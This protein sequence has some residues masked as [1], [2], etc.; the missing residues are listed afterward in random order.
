MG[1]LGL[2]D[3]D[4]LD[5]GCTTHAFDDLLR[6]LPS[7]VEVGTARLVRLWPFASGRTRG[8]A[9][10]SVELLTKNEAA[11]MEH[12]ED[13]WQTS[14][15]HLKGQ[16]SISHHS[17]RQ[18][19]STD[20][21]MV[22]FSHQPDES[23]YWMTVRGEV[24]QRDLPIP[25]KEWG[26]L[27][28][29]G[30]IAAA[31]WPKHH[32]T[33]EGIAWRE[34]SSPNTP[35]RVCEKTLKDIDEWPDTFLSR[36]PRRGVSLIAP[37]GPSPVLLGVRATSESTASAALSSLLESQDTEQASSFRIFQTNQASGDHL[38]GTRRVTIESVDVVRER[39]HATIQS[40]DGAMI[41]YAEGGPINRLARWLQP[42]DVVDVRGL[43][44]PQGSLHIEQMKLVSAKARQRVRPSCK[45]C[46]VRMKSM[47][48][49]QGIRCPKC[50]EQHAD[51]WI[52]LEPEPPYLDWI[53]PP[54]THRR[55]LARPLEWGVPETR[56]EP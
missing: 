16:H 53:E 17:S 37:R 9:A 28:C 11:L 40:S 3:T 23:A 30:A 38:D 26:G 7:D 5:E 45:M 54:A 43:H 24:K 29:I 42:G 49:N 13:W 31:A 15:V 4:T 56:F 52:E 47:G 10:V 34:T 27:G 50:R 21:G 20:P 22:W 44:D 35:R 2:D 8:N 12:L 14:L 55:H 19:Q 51:A 18:Q 36:D 6:H 41:A 39:K 48:A 1:W 33:W 46:E 32:S 25:D